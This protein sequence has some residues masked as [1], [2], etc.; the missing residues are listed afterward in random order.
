MEFRQ[1]LEVI[2]TD[3]LERYI[4]QCISDKFD[5]NGLALQDLVNEVGRRLGFTVE[6]GRYRGGSGHLG[7]DGVWRSSTGHDLVIEVKTTSGFTIDLDSLAGYRDELIAGGAIKGE[8]SSV[9][10]VV[11]RSENTA[12]I[13]AQIRG[14][15]ACLGYAPRRC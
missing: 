12:S 2:S 11:G 3:L 13:E 8:R 1:F 10:I 15:R 5:N 7:H 4:S 6:R 14:S 9:L